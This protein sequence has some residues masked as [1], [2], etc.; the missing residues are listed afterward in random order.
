MPRW[1][2]HFR[3]MPTTSMHGHVFSTISCSMQAS[4]GCILLSWPSPV[5]TSRTSFDLATA[6][7]TRACVPSFTKDSAGYIASMASRSFGC[8]VM[9]ISWLEECLGHMPVAWV[10]CILHVLPLGRSTLALVKPAG[11]HIFTSSFFFSHVN[12][13][14]SLKARIYGIAIWSNPKQ[15]P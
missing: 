15:I 1:R 10:T 5:T 11:Q 12:T 7:E 6:R 2:A 3:F 9:T 13:A 4:T 8:A 14:L